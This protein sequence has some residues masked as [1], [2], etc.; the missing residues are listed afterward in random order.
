MKVVFCA[1]APV[2]VCKTYDPTMQIAG[3]AV[4]AFLLAVHTTLLGLK[5]VRAWKRRRGKLFPFLSLALFLFVDKQYW[6]METGS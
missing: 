2:T 3:I 5:A 1:V 4:N 6:R